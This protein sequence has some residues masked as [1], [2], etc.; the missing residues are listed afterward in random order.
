MHTYS[1][2]QLINFPLLDLEV[3]RFGP[4]EHL[5]AALA[6]S[7]VAVVEALREVRTTF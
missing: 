5:S 4:A 1:E 2:H 6:E 3:T 7:I